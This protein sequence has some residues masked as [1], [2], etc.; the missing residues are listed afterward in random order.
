MVGPYDSDFRGYY[1]G[2]FCC[3]WRISLDIR[4]TEFKVAHYRA[5]IA[6][7]K[8]VYHTVKV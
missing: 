5:A 7:D 1:S 2:R 8:G 3:Y 4:E 6:L